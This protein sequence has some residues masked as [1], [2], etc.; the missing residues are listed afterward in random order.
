M[1]LEKN[2]KAGDFLTASLIDIM[3]EM[4]KNGGNELETVVSRNKGNDILI[5]ISFEEVLND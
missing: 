1:K 3:Q 5:K 4:V 2:G